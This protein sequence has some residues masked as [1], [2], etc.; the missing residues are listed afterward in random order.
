VDDDTAVREMAAL[1]LEK[2]G[3]LV[4]R[5]SSAAAAREAIRTARP[6]LVLC[7]IYM[8]GTDG[9]SFL[10]EVRG[11]T[12]PI[13]VILMTARGSVETAAVAA[14]TGA[15]D[16][17]AKPFD[18]SEL[19][20]RVR[21]ALAPRPE[22]AAPSDAGPESMII[23]SHPAMVEVYKAIARVAPLRV[24]VLVTGETGTGKELVARALHQFGAAP[25]GPFV[26][27]HCAAIPENLL[28]SE[29][30]GHRRGAFTDAV[31]DRRGALSLADGGTF[32][33]DEVG[34]VPPAFQVKLLRVLEEGTVQPVGA[35]RAEPVDVRFVAATH[36]DIPA[37]VSVGRFRQDLSYRLAGYEIHLPPLRE[38]LSDLPFLVSHFQTRI[39]RELGLSVT[40]A[41]AVAVMARFAA[42]AWPGNVRELANVVRRLLIDGRSL[43]DEVAAARLLGQ[44]APATPIAEP[45]SRTLEEAERRHIL[46]VLE[47]TGGNKSEAARVLGI[48]RKT[49][50]R[51]LKRGDADEG[52]EP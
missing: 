13:P 33:L 12:D 4:V 51:K 48:E 6:D 22:G 34:E 41:P 43:A 16:Y 42:H 28:E 47:E 49:L 21:A 52:D 30:F 38:R 50:A 37:M 25:D 46:K 26:P 36:R 3:F 27:V 35:E 24:P 2:S 10:A 40:G 45:D 31:R 23:G 29:L 9:L 5:A 1:A 44:A 19:V 11:V 7:D 18:L 20:A 8:P 14:R 15:F 17:L 39:E 32:F